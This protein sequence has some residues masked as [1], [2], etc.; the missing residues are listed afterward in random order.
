MSVV[1][2]SSGWIEVLAGTDRACYYESALHADSLIVPSIVR[3]EVCRYALAYRGRDGCELAL[4]ALGKFEQV[5]IDEA[6][7]DAAAEFAQ[8]FKLATA[9]ALIYAVTMAWN[10]EIWT[11]DRHFDGLPQVKYFEK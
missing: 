2:D 1:L 4:S 7:A 8:C 10:A 11:Q 6:I 3:Y 5:P 9:D